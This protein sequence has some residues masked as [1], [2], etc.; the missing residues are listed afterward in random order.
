MTLSQLLLVWAGPLRE[1]VEPC[2]RPR[3]VISTRGACTV[4]PAQ[5]EQ[6]G[7]WQAAMGPRIFRRPSAP[8]TAQ[9]Q[10]S[11]DPLGLVYRPAGPLL[12]G[13]GVPGE[14]G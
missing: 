13:R 5:R 4:G 11:E 3:R 10:D 8:A 12:R 1:P 14:E 9:V 6:D 7:P 2:G